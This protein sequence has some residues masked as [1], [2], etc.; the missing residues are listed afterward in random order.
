MTFRSVCALML[1]SLLLSFP[2]SAQVPGHLN[3][4][5][6]LLSGTNLYNGTVSMRFRLYTNE[7]DTTIVFESTQSVAVADGLYAARIGENVLVGHLALTLSQGDIWLQVVVNGTPLE[8]RE[9]LA[10]APYAIYPGLKGQYNAEWSAWATVGGGLSNAAFNAYGTIGGGKRNVAMGIG[11]TIAGGE[12]NVTSNMLCVVGG[13]AQNVAGSLGQGYA[14]VAGGYQCRAVGF[15]SVVGGGW[16]NV[17]TGENATVSG[18]DNNF[19]GGKSSTVPGG[20]LNVAG[21]DNSFA[22]GHAAYAFH[23]GSFVWADETSDFPFLSTSSNQFLIRASQGVG[24]NTNATPEALTV[25]GNVKAKAFIGNGASLT[26]VSGSAI[27]N[28]SITTQ[29][30]AVA[31]VGSTQLMPSAVGGAHLQDGTAVRSINALT[32]QVTLQ[33]AG[34]ITVSSQSQ[35]LTIANENQLPPSAIVL[36]RTSPNDVLE[37]NGFNLVFETQDRDSWTQITNDAA[38]LGRRNACGLSFLGKLFFFGGQ[39]NGGTTNTVWFSDDGATWFQ[40]PFAQWGAR[41]R[42]AA[43]VFSNRMWIAGGSLTVSGNKTNDVW[44]TENGFG[45]TAATL[46]APWGGRA[47]HQLLAFDG[48]LW[49]L[50]GSGNNF[51][52]DVWNTTNGSN[53]TRVTTAPWSRREGFGACIFKDRIWVMGGYGVGVSRTNDVWSSADGSNWVCATPQAEWAARSEHGALTYDNKLWVMGGYTG[54]I[55]QTSDAWYSENG[56]NWTSAGNADWMARAGFVSMIHSGRMW[57]V[58]GLTSNGVYDDDVWASG[59][60][61]KSGRFFLYEKR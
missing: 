61:D 51:S 25:N 36:S 54:S 34:G 9:R 15:D 38:F 32:D 8:P 46:N 47:L 11:S 59:A 41:Y 17:A 30:L 27:A 42:A 24:I 5:G 37:T 21:G 4:Q 19:A 52:N 56:S 60:P 45:W 26:N 44:W 40:A 50:G 29:Q 18:G 49:L 39:G 33:G 23:N 14:T 10:S 31:S 22:A 16:Q 12:D 35:T 2:A 3:Y 57:A 6:R 7:T 43:A 20:N 55:T 58:S 48:K 28:G 13:G 1:L 53:W